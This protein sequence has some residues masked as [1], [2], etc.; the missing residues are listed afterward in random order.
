MPEEEEEDL[1]EDELEKDFEEVEQLGNLDDF[2]EDDE[3]E[4]DFEEESDL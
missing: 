1:I 3:D 2:D 4:E